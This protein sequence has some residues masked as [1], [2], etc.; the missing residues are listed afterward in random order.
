[1]SSVNNPIRPQTLHG[2]NS[3][4]RVSLISLFLGC[5]DLR[6]DLYLNG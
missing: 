5:V 1:M 6:V 3:T 2:N 4:G